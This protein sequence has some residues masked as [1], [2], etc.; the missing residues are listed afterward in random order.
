[1]KIQTNNQIGTECIT[2]TLTHC[3][4]SSPT[5]YKQLFCTKV[6][7]TA[8]LYLPICTIIFRQK[9]NGAKTPHKMLVEFTTGVILNNIFTTFSSGSTCFVVPFSAYNLAFKF[10]VERIMAQ[11][12]A[13]INCCK[14]NFKMIFVVEIDLTEHLLRLRLAARPLAL[15]QHHDRHRVDQDESTGIDFINV[16]LKTFCKKSALQLF[17]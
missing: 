12:A 5:F 2:C 17:L 1:M 16:L 8:F 3:V 9:N 7:Y 10:F 15:L 14:L 11:K 4:S 13:R 6:F